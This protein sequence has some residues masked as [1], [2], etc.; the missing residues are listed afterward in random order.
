MIANRALIASGATRQTTSRNSSSLRC[1][2]VALIRLLELVIDSIE[3]REYYRTG[4]EWRISRFRTSAHWLPTVRHALPLTPSSN[5]RHRQSLSGRNPK[6]FLLQFAHC[7]CLYTMAR[8][9]LHPMHADKTRLRRGN[10]ST[11][12]RTGPTRI[13]PITREVCGFSRGQVDR[14]G[15]H[16]RR[17]P[18]ALA[19]FLLALWQCDF[20]EF[21]GPVQQ[22]FLLE[23][24]RGRI[25]ARC[26]SFGDGR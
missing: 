7:F 16:T 25:R 4:I 18:L 5:F 23:V 1:E 20:G 17:R 24:L 19:I 8:H 21:D 6:R 26:A 15:N 9:V 3:T 12:F 22:C 10:P 11:I 14:T 2:A 13:V